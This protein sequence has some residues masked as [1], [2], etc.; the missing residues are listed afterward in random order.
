MK[1]YVDLPLLFSN[2]AQ[3]V[4]LAGS[5]VPRRGRDL[6]KLGVLQNA[7]VL[8]TGSRIAAVGPSRQVEREASREKALEVDC[9]GNIVMPGFVDSH[10]HLVFAGHRVG[11]FAKRIRGQTYEQIAKG[12]GGIQ[13]SARRLKQ[14]TV[15]QLAA[16]AEVHLQ[17]FIAHGTTTLEAKSGYGLDVASELK[18][19]EAIRLLRQTALAE[20]VP[21]LLA[22]HAFPANY[23]R[24]RE[25]YIR[26]IVTRL[27]PQVGQE[28]LAEFVDCFCD[29]GAFTVAECREVLQAGLRHHLPARVHAEQLAHTGATQLAV[30][31]AAVSADHLDKVDRADIQALA[32]SNV[33]ASLVPGANYHLGLKT[34]PPARPLI[35]AG[36]IVALATDF[37][38]GTCPTPN[39]QFILSLACSALRL[40][41]EEAISA[42]TLNGAFALRR[43]HRLGSLE[44]GKDADLVVM[45]VPDYRE[46]PYYFGVNHCIMTVKRGRI[47]YSVQS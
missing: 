16:Q 10:T 44:R 24:G 29:R 3:V 12:G 30:E 41:P 40:T 28:R 1:R 33:V 32:R 45:D 20:I 27:I 7:A 9:R 2:A 34:Y 26:E 8:V 35:D 38:P 5:P 47:I 42:A 46:L 6:G 13:S 18:I 4:T 23:R 11:D 36:A 14:S 25:A 19:L 17:R 21:T 15:A 39:M 37:N 22:A 31:V 43:S